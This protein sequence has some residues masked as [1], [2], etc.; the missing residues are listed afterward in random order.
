M[1]QGVQV[2][3]R[4][5]L[6]TA[7]ALIATA[8]TRPARRAGSRSELVWVTGGLNAGDQG[9][10][11]D[12]AAR[13]NA[14][15]PAGPIARVEGLSPAADEQR[16]VLALELNAGLSNVDIFELDID[17]TAEFAQREWLVDLHELRS[18]VE[19]VSLPG[20][21]Q[22][23]TWD[24]TL[25]AAPYTADAGIL[26]YRSDLVGTAPTTWEELIE[27]GRRVSADQNGM[28]PFV[29]DGAQYEGLVL[30]YLEYFWG[31]GGNVLSGDGSVS[32]PL[33]KALQ[34]AEFMRTAFREGVYA[35]GFN[36]M[37]LDQASNTFESG[38]A[39][40][41]RLWP[42]AYRNM[43]GGGPDS[44]VAGKVGIAPLP[45]FT[46]HGPV[47]ARGGQ[48]LAVSAFS[49]NIS[50]AVEFVRF[51]STSREV[52]R[53]LAERH[54]RAPTLAAAYHDLRDDPLMTLLARVL[55]T[56]RPRPATKA[57]SVISEEIQQQIFAAYTGV[58]E[59][60]VAVENLRRFLVATVG[61][62]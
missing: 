13:W 18:E 61:G 28:A 37:E 8:C 33:D 32:F 10:A 26:Y 19:R 6:A 21:V 22:T 40:F 24:G 30:Q 59:P 2:S 46:G 4:A 27:V 42:Y 57:W 15:H 11:R 9:P 54:S 52:Q 39:I 20:S 23:A 50:A 5:A 16:Q 34:A 31:L 12:I 62:G 55:P 44:Q 25:W 51:A 45:A 49:R 36:T 41:M 38:E 43:T 14:L 17:W 29:A 48:N 53:G 35:P 1:S 58:V 3:R 56:A 7:A 60:G 47:A